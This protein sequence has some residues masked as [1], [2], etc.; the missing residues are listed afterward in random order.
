MLGA[1]EKATGRWLFHGWSTNLHR[2][3]ESLTLR[4]E[5]AKKP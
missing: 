3:F 1:H 2:G 5:I 4:Q